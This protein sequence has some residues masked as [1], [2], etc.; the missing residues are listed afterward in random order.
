MNPNWQHMFESF[1]E[2]DAIRGLLAKRGGGDFPDTPSR[3][4]KRAKPM[5][6]PHL[7]P[8]KVTAKSK[9]KTNRN[10]DVIG[11][12]RA[13][14]FAKPKQPKQMLAR[15]GAPVLLAGNE[16]DAEHPDAQEADESLKLLTDEQLLKGPGIKRSYHKRVAKKTACAIV[17]S[18]DICKKY[19]GSQG[20]RWPAFQHWHRRQLG[21]QR[22]SIDSV[23]F[24]V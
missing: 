24:L 21:F 10:T 15:A 7:S 14:S 2:R 16:D 23:H 22:G 3:N 1:G 9:P 8:D 20:I 6:E 4:T 19:L 13:A 12:C 11:D 17:K 18:S 5:S